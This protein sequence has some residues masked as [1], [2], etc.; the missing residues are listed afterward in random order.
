MGL[1]A[2]FSE[3]SLIN[4]SSRRD[5]QSFRKRSKSE[6]TEGESWFLSLKISRS[7]LKYFWRRSNMRRWLMKLWRRYK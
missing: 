3:N 1:L 5:S 7:R 6:L 4:L 2:S